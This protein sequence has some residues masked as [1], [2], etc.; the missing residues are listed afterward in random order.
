[1]IQRSLRA[2]VVLCLLAA[3]GCR[4]G[5]Y[6]SQGTGVVLGG[7][8]SRRTRRQCD[9]RRRNWSVDRRGRRR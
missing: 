1:M 9:R 5:Y 8:G 3:I 6:Q 2:L 7:G 4:S